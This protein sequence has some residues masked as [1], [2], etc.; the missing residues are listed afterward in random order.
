MI[1]KIFLS[2]CTILIFSCQNK[3]KLTHNFYYMIRE[4]YNDTILVLL[5]QHKDSFRGYMYHSFVNVY[6]N[7]IAGKRVNDTISIFET[8][9]ENTEYYRYSIFKDKD[10]LKAFSYLGN[11]TDKYNN[12]TLVPISEKK[13]NDFL[14]KKNIIPTPLPD[15][16]MDTIT[17]LFKIELVA[18]HR[19][20]NYENNKIVITIRDKTTNAIIQT[21]ENDSIFVRDKLYTNLQDI[22][23]DGYIDMSFESVNRGS[24]GT[25]KS[26]DYIYSPIQNKFIYHKKLNELNRISVF[27][28]LDSINQRVLSEQVSGYSW[29][30]SEAYQYKGDSLMLVKSLEA[31]ETDYLDYKYT[32]I[33]Y[34]NGEKNKKIFHFNPYEI[35]SVQ[36]K[37]K[38]EHI[39]K[40]YERF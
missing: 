16:R 19:N 37:H 7:K 4:P 14:Y 5:N 31:D 11:F 24:Y 18:T 9:Y 21:I 33:H 15:M 30:L 20:S 12:F 1:K 10:T 13:F 28:G 6:I 26:E 8:I 36:L 25:Y 32:I 39:Y 38:I 2:L 35:D 40:Q 23:F 17:D 34:K 22:S 3:D 29:H 27:I